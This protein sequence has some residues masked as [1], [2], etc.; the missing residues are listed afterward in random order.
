[1]LGV[2]GIALQCLLALKGTV[3]HDVGIRRCQTSVNVYLDVYES[4]NFTYQAFETFLNTCLNG[5]LLV[6]RE[7]WIQCLENNVLYHK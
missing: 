5:L 3:E 7:F 1:M 2:N 6:F 4:G